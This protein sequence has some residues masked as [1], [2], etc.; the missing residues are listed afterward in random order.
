[1]VPPII[2]CQCG[3]LHRDEADELV[4]R[5]NMVEEIDALGLLDDP[6]TWHSDLEKIVFKYGGK[7]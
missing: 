3:T 7:P 2:G 1:M 5:W 4:R 6:N